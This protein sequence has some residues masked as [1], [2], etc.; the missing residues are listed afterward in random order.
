M[1][2]FS[3]GSKGGSSDVII[4]P[5]SVNKTS[6]LFPFSTDSQRLYLSTMTTIVTLTKY[7]IK[8]KPCSF[9]F[10]PS[11]FVF[12]KRFYVV[13]NSVLFPSIWRT[14]HFKT[15]TIRHKKT[16]FFFAYSEEYCYF[17]TLMILLELGRKT[18]CYGIF[19]HKSEFNNKQQT[20]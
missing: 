10:L 1:T 16:M 11:P 2:L 18:C 13:P 14:C 15:L 6:Q 9:L 8:P 12:R 7:S 17:M 4:E 3:V 20:W 5:R 19:M